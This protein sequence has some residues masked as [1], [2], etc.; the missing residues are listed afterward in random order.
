[1]CFNI[2]ISNTC[3]RINLQILLM[4]AIMRRPLSLTQSLYRCLASPKPVLSHR[5][6]STLA[7]TDTDTAGFTVPVVTSLDSNND[8]IQYLY[9]NH[10]FTVSAGLTEDQKE[11]Q[12]LAKDFAMKELFPNMST[13]DQE[14]IFPVDVLRYVNR[15]EI[16]L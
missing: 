5:L 15:P 2:K 7:D 1:M 6:Q 11:M 3:F 13:W 14:E 8:T 12:S 10:H 4:A 9:C 16:M